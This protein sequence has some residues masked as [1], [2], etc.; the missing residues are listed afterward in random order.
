MSR[1]VIGDRILVAHVHEGMHPEVMALRGKEGVV[2]A[3]I[4]GPHDDLVTVEF[5][6]A[7]TSGGAGKGNTVF[8]QSA[9]LLHVVVDEIDDDQAH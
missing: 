7:V 9:D 5:P 2:R 1:F 3:V 6:F 4:Q 8:F